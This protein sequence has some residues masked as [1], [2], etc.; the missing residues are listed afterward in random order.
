MLLRF[1]NSQ[2]NPMGLICPLLII[3]KINL[4][5]LFSS[6]T[7]LG[8]DDRIPDEWHEKWVAILSMFLRIGNITLDRAVRP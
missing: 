3:L 2:Y 1:V 5:D 4:R 8:W 6:I 7:D